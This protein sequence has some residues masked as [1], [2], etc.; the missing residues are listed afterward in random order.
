MRKYLKIFVLAMVVLVALGGQVWAQAP[1][2]FTYQGRLTDDAGDAITSATSVTFAIYAT[3]TGGTALYNTT[4]SITPNGDGVFTVELGPVSLST[5]DGSKLYLGIKVGSDSEMSPRQILTSAPYAMS[6]G[7]APGLAFIESLPGNIFR[8][9]PSGTTALDSISITVPGPGYVY[10]WASTTVTVDHTAGITDELY[11][12]VAEV[13]GTID[14]QDFGFAMVIIPGE[15]PT[16]AGRYYGQHVDAH[17][18]FAVNAAGTYK[19]YFNSR[20]QYGS[21]DNDSFFD[22]NMTAM[23][24]PTAYGTVDLISSPPKTNDELPAGASSTE[25]VSY[26]HL[27]AHE[28]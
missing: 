22:L 9:I 4:R 24:F 15:L 7:N 14:F 28:T 20:V 8:N 25:T 3:P 10:V 5:F 1:N 23:Y 11:F 27:R 17:R 19:Y 12:Q 2:T 16:Q 26:T 6:S 18:P 13:A 21:G